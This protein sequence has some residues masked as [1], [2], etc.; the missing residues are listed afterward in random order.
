MRA[1]TQTR[2]Q[3]ELCLWSWQPVHLHQTPD[4]NDKKAGQ[5]LPRTYR[6]T[7]K[8]SESNESNKELRKEQKKTEKGPNMGGHSPMKTCQMVAFC[9]FQ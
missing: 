5:N 4:E 1:I 8:T 7:F 6:Y 9:Q 3:G 2:E